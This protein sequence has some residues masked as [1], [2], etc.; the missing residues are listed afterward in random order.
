MNFRPGNGI[1]LGKVIL[2]ATVFSTAMIGLGVGLGIESNKNAVRTNE[3]NKLKEDIKVTEQITND[4]N[5]K[6]PSGFI[7]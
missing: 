3:L 7:N 2:G 6:P 5:I 1:G 4:I